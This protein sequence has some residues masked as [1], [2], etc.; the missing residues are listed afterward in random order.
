MTIDAQEEWIELHI[1]VDTTF[2]FHDPHSR[3]AQRY[4]NDTEKGTI[5]LPAS[6]AMISS[7]LKLCLPEHIL[8]IF[9]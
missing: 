4:H 8:T 9:S 7:L 3:I 6:L 2:V 1:Y 5:L